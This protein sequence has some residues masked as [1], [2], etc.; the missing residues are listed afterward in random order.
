MVS[1]VKEQTIM[2]YG[3]ERRVDEACFILSFCHAFDFTLIPNTHNSH[4]L[5]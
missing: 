1:H 2:G 5:L 4:L 3:A